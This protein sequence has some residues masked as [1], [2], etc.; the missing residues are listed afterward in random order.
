[1][2]K[3]VLVWLWI[4]GMLTVCLPPAARAET[5]REEAGETVRNLYEDVAGDEWFAD[6]AEEMT[7][8][9]LMSGVETGRFAPYQEVNRATI[10]LILW[11]MEGSP[12]VDTDNP[13]PD[14][15]DWY[16]AAANWAKSVGVTSGYAGGAFGGRDHLTREQLAV[17]LYQYALYK[18]EP[19]AEGVLELYS[20]AAQVSD[21]AMTAVRHAVGAG[22]LQGGDGDVLNPQG[23]ANR[24]A[25]AVMLRRMLTPAVG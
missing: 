17:F 7:R 1:M 3:R 16:A 13:F 4:L 9:G 5:L 8:L 6:A 21:W 23:T 11:R 2:K 10:V 22:I 15:E 24:A 20:D 14:L 18:G 19:I 12:L 25:L